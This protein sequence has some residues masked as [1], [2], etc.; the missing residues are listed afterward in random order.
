M[1]KVS[2]LI[3]SVLVIW[4]VSETDWVSSRTSSHVKAGATPIL[5][6]VGPAAKTI[7]VGSSQLV[8][9]LVIRATSQQFKLTPP[10]FTSLL[11][12]LR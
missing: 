12:T 8:P 3:V 10:C 11:V 6:F 1:K 7:A 5:P 4:A 2:R 9:E